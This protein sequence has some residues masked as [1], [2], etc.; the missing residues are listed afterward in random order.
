M[1]ALSSKRGRVFMKENH[2]FQTS[3]ACI[4]H[5]ISLLAIGVLLLNDHVLKAASPSWFTGKLSD[6]AGLYFFPFIVAAGLS[7]GLSRLHLTTKQIGILSFA[8]VAVWFIALKIFPAANAVT[9]QFAVAVLGRPTRFTLDA[10]DLIALASLAPAWSFWNQRRKSRP[11][12]LGYIALCIGAIAA[13]ATS[14][15]QPPVIVE[16]LELKDGI[17]YATAPTYPAFM[18][19]NDGKTWQDC[20]Q[21]SCPDAPSPKRPPQMPVTICDP[22]SSQ[23]CYR[24]IGTPS[25]EISTDGGKSWSIGWEVPP[26]RISFL[27]RRGEVPVPRDLIIVQDS[28]RYLLVAMGQSGILRRSLPDGQWEQISVY[29]A[30]PTPLAANSAGE[31]LGFVWP[32][33]GIWLAISTLILVIAGFLVWLESRFEDYRRLDIVSW[34]LLTVVRAAGSLIF[35]ILILLFTVP[36]IFGLLVCVWYAAVFVSFHFSVQSL[37]RK[38]I[39]NSKVQTTLWRTCILMPIVNCLQASVIWPLWASGVIWDYQVALALSGAASGIILV[40]G[41]LL[42]PRN[43]PIGISLRL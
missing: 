6:F 14:P 2:A 39:E 35:G 30:I 20:F 37:I 43:G 28:D 25:V 17:V 9:A 11:G 8:F 26:A 4:Q 36:D 3:L 21:N 42:P 22:E 12:K 29:S 32:E 16:A 19:G 40:I 15:A 18:S 23:T 7:L 31:A 1:R 27:E 5:P 10:T 13:M 41:A 24:I 38:V 33:L 34:T